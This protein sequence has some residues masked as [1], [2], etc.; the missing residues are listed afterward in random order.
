MSASTPS[1]ERIDYSLRTNKNIERKLVFEK[2]SSLSS[3]LSFSDYRYLG[4]GSLWFVDFVMAHR[5]LGIRNLCSMEKEVNAD[6]AEF[7][8]P[9]YS[10]EIRPGDANRLLAEMPADEWGK[11]QVVWLDYD[12]RY[13]DDA[14]DDCRLV[15]ERGKVGT[16]LIATANAHRGSY[17][18]GAPD[19]APPV[20]NT[21]REMLG[22]AVP[23]LLPSGS[24]ADVSETD[25]PSFLGTS[26]LGH[27]GSCVRTSGRQTDEMP[28]RFIPLFNFVHRDNVPMV[29][30]GGLVGSWRM[31]ED[32]E[33]HFKAEASD[34]FQGAACNREMLDLVPITIKEK[35]SLDSLLPCDE[36]D[37]QD[38]ASSRGIKLSID[39]IMKYRRLYP[40]FPLFGEMGF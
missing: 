17:R 23:A 34:L 15:L 10:I 9:Y 5:M 30:V 2:L 8:K 6:R 27:M 40:H 32:L 1:F 11:P 4:F 38:R 12:G 24:A 29:T 35:L 22:D 18:R 19:V 33:R 36:A 16:I 13:D 26:I 28:D 7:N 14:R 21:L 25:F 3:I 20:V 39:Q 31:L 37:V